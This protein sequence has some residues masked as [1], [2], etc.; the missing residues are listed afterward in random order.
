VRC[1]SE[2]GT[3]EYSGAKTL[4]NVVLRFRECE[5]GLPAGRCTSPGPAEGEIVTQPLTGELGIKHR[6]AEGPVKDEI[7]LG[8]SP[9]GGVFAEFSCPG[10]AGDAIR[11][12]VLVPVVSNLMDLWRNRPFKSTKGKQKP[13]RL[14]GGPRTVLEV[15]FAGEPFEQVGLT[16]TILQTNEERVEISSVS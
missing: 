9:A 16:A 10:T 14:E 3:G 6:S 13:E 15:S 5:E 7:A 11:G 2:S 1:A 8:L 12:S 4:A